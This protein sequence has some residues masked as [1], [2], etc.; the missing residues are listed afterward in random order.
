MRKLNNKIK[1]IGAPILAGVLACSTA[2][3]YVPQMNAVHAD[4]EKSINENFPEML[5]TAQIRD[6]VRGNGRRRQYNRCF[7]KRVAEE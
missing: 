3:F 5:K 7:G 2:L 1:K 4:T 6:R